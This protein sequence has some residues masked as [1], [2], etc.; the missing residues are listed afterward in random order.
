MGKKRLKLIG[1]GEHFL[2]KTPM[3]LALRSTNDKWDFM[4]L[5]TSRSQRT[6]LIG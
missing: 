2:K 3:S 5:K 6:L 4:K 1:T